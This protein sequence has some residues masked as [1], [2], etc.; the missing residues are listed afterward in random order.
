M[1]RTILPQ[2]SARALFRKTVVLLRTLWESSN[3]PA[4]SSGL[5]PSGGSGR[6]SIGKKF[7]ETRLMV[8]ITLNT[9]S[10]NFSDMSTI[11]LMVVIG[12]KYD[13][14]YPKEQGLQKAGGCEDGREEQEM[15][16]K[17]RIKEL[18]ERRRAPV[19]RGGCSTDKSAHHRL[20]ASSGGQQQ[21]QQASGI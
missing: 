13:W 8:Q 9:C 19:L 16:Q 11:S 3:L 1:R 4:H 6:P 17:Y 18:L 21:H 14:D 20:K 7:I 15:D 12:R 2:R 5:S 10:D